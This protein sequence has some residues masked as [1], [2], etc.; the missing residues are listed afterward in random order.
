MVLP[1]PDMPRTR[2]LVQ[3]VPEHELVLVFNSDEDAERFSDWL[4]NLGW[5]AFSEWH[6]KTQ[7]DLAAHG[8]GG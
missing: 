3:S 5:S 8:E 4:E 1:M 6:E 7:T 2:T